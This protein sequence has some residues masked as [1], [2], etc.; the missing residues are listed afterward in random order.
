MTTRSF[1]LKTGCL[2]GLCLCQLSLSQTG[3]MKNNLPDDEVLRR[4]ALFE[5]SLPVRPG[6]L[7]TPFWNVYSKRFICAPAF[8]N[9]PVPGAD[10]YLYSLQD[11]QGNRHEFQAASPSAPLSPIWCDVPVGQSDLT[12]TAIGKDGQAIGKPFLRSLYR[13]A[14]YPSTPPKR[15]CGYRESARRAMDYLFNL[16]HYQKWI[17][18]GQPDDS[19][20]LYCYPSKIMSSVI[21]SMIMYSKLEPK[22]HD[23]ALLIACKAADFMISISEPASQ[24]LAYM[25]PT[26]RGEKRVSK[27]FAGQ[28]MMIYPANAAMSYLSLFDVTGNQAYREAALNIAQTYRK[29]QLPNGTWYLKMQTSDGKNVGPNLCV[30]LEMIEL[31]QRLERQYGLSEYHDVARKAYE[32]IQTTVVDTFNWEGQFE[33]QEPTP[34]YLNLTK[35]NAC[36]FAMYLF[37]EF[38]TDNDKTALAEELVRFAEDQFVVWEK[39]LPNPSNRTS[40]WLLPCVLEQYAYYVP[41]DASAAKLIRTFVAA[42]RQTGKPLYLAKACRLADAMTCAQRPDTGRYPTYWETNG[43]L[44]APGWINCATMDA[45]AMME[46]ADLLGE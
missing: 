25:P 3:T 41:I 7:S 5:S 30:P 4:Q 44:E 37:A 13:A 14:V 35:H 26:Y 28:I 43:R 40:Q 33:D 42:Y 31:F 46:L 39:P 1:W 24:P 8:D 2:A 19:Y 15:A 10:H 22:A 29:L 23:K 27:Q 32:Y 9:V 17:L 20:D 34:P 21:D 11:C 45:V 36:S 6:S 16:Q 18:T 12:V 38:P